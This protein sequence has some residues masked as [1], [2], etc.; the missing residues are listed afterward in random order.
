MDNITSIANSIKNVIRLRCPKC[1]HMVTA[2]QDY[3]GGRGKCPDCGHI[4]E[5]P[6]L[7]RKN[8]SQILENINYP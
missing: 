5:I 1:H 3:A 8:P 2:P 6:N 4:V 7:K